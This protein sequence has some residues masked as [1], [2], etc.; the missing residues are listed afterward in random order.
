MWSDN[1]AQKKAQEMRKIYIASW[2]PKKELGKAT[3]GQERHW[4]FPKF[5]SSLRSSI[6]AIVKL[7]SHI[8]V[9]SIDSRRVAALFLCPSSQIA[10]QINNQQR[11]R[12]IGN[13]I[14][15]PS[16][17]AWLEQIN[18]SPKNDNT[19]NTGSWDWKAIKSKRCLKVVDVKGTRLTVKKKKHSEVKEIIRRVINQNPS[20]QVH[21]LSEQGKKESA[22]RFSHLKTF[23]EAWK[24]LNTMN[25]IG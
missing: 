18:F 14:F 24:R 9:S 17:L 22:S 13:S 25:E 21:R 12:E 23:F 7:F 10:Q 5:A 19:H 1:G 4:N 2:S 3:R 20:W 16:D 15:L 8:R 6:M 11:E